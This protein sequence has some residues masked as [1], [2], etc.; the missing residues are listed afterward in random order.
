M[1]RRPTAVSAHSFLTAF[2]ESILQTT[3]M[4]ATLS[5]VFGGLAYLYYEEHPGRPPFG[6]GIGPVALQARKRSNAWS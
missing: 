1:V 2:F 5:V 3:A 6:C 4:T